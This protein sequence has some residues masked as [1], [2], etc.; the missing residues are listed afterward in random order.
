MPQT[1]QKYVRATG[2]SQS[3]GDRES[4]HWRRN[5]GAGSSVSLSLF[6][7]CLLLL[8]G[9]VFSVTNYPPQPVFIWWLYVWTNSAW[10]P[11]HP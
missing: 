8:L 1:L 6:F 4:T 5:E 7:V 3:D 9:D 2:G 10:W 11:P